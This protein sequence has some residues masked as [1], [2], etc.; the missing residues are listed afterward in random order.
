[1]PIFHKMT[2]CCSMKN[3][4]YILY[5]GI[6]GSFVS[7]CQ[8]SA[9]EEVMLP[10]NHIRIT[11][12]LALDEL[13]SS[14]R[15]TWSDNEASTGALAGNAYENQIDLKS[16]NGL[17]VFIYSAD[18]QTCLSEVV[19]GDVGR[20]EENGRTVYQFTGDAEVDS[21]YISNG[22]LNCRLMVFA[23]C[24]DISATSSLDG[25]YYQFNADAF[26]NQS[27]YIPMWGVKECALNMEQ[28]E[29]SMVDGYIYLLRSMSK[30]EV[31]LDS[32]VADMFDLQ[33]VKVNKYNT[34]GNVM[35]NGYKAAKLTEAMDQETVFN[36]NASSVD[37][38]LAFVKVSADEYYVYLPE[39]QNI[40]TSAA[41]MT[42]TVD[43]V[44]Y[45]L[46]FKVYDDDNNDANDVYFNLVRNHCYQYIIT[47]VR[48]NENV[49]LLYQSIPWTDVTNGNLVFGKG[50]GN[51]MN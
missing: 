27:T 39:Y 46:E 21:R 20:L 51:A 16:D 14:S 12:T 47:G 13:N 22:R 48:T 17:Q 38:D 49:L 4:L 11:F 44:N 6:L 29:V 28:G 30:V 31:K 2:I 41:R 3:W 1:M 24:N 25:L 42:V 15:A 33:N 7:S 36:P 40:G 5:I 8:Q 32:S 50:D 19:D 37:S 43:G 35:P 45:P 18:G 10:S 23:N 34:K 26:V 9:D